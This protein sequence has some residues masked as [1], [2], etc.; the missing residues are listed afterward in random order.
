MT[1]SH[2]HLKYR[3]L[4]GLSSLFPSLFCLFWNG[5]RLAEVVKVVQLSKPRN[6]HWYNALSWGTGFM[7]IFY[8]PFMSFSHLRS[9]IVVSYCIPWAFPICANSSAFPCFFHDLDIFEKLWLVIHGMFFNLV[10]SAVSPYHIE[11]MCIFGKKHRSDFA[12]FHL[13]HGVSVA[14]GGTW[15]HRLSSCLIATDVTLIF[16]LS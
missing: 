13:Q 12:P 6:S 7:L 1:Y 3:V 14:E 11:I 16:W 9:H 4:Y 2:I 10:S 5:F 15:F 8:I